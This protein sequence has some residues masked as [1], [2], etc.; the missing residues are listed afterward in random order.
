MQ[1]CAVS[2]VRAVIQSQQRRHAAERYFKAESWCRNAVTLQ[3]GTSKLQAAVVTMTCYACSCGVRAQAALGAL[4][5][6]GGSGCSE[7]GD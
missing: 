3:K 6:A 5:N 2:D 4:S 1:A 7:A